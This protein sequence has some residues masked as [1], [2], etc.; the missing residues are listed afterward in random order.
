MSNPLGHGSTAGIGSKVGS[1]A[2][3]ALTSFNPDPVPGFPDTRSAIVRVAWTPLRRDPSHRS[4]MTNQ[5]VLGEVVE[6]L[7][8]PADA[9]L[10]VR[11]ADGYEGQVTTG[12][13]RQ[14]GEADAVAWTAAADGFS[15]GTGLEPA[16][17]APWG[18]RLARAGDGG[19]LLPDGDRVNARRPERIVFGPERALAYEADAAAAA[20]TARE[21][22]GTP[23][24][25]GG[26]IRAG[27]DCSGFVQAVYGLHGIRLPRDSR[28]Q[29]EAGPRLPDEADHATRGR[30]GDLWFFAW[31]DGPVSH[32][33]ICLGN[34]AMIHAS[35]TRGAVAIDRIGEGEFG[36]RLAA[37]LVG[38]TRP[39]RRS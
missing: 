39:E 24:Q 12:A 31:D 34:G 20:R 36:R 25:W 5:L 18:A 4:E 6:L 13:L 10:T 17:H 28:D 21:W 19:F 30:S 1:M 27:A 15:L 32:V 35:E 2:P 37:G 33:G 14:V 7:E 38:A 9:W 8:Q 29:F 11:A 23:Y 22:M 26:R 3:G 16:G